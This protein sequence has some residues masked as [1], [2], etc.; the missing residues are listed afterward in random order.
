MPI[1][2]E[3]R[4]DFRQNQHNE[5]WTVFDIFTGSPAEVDGTYLT[6]CSMEDADDLVDLLN[7]KYI[8]RRSA[9]KK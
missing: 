3:N 6:H 7:A 9:S 5:L 8:A 1:K 4:Y 2:S